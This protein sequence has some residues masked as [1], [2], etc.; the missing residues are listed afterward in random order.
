MA[1]VTRS[2]LKNKHETCSREDVPEFGPQIS[3]DKVYVANRHFRWVKHVKTKLLILLQKEH[4]GKTDQCRACL[5]Q[6][7]VSFWSH[8]N[9]QSSFYQIIS[10]VFHHISQTFLYLLF[11]LIFLKHPINLFRKFLLLEQ[12]T[13]HSLLKEAAQLLSAETGRWPSFKSPSFI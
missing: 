10:I 5:L 2:V 9:T 11:F 4:I 3:E 13:R 1:V 7:Q 8:K 6:I 12:Q